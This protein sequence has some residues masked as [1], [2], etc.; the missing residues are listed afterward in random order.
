MTDWDARAE[1]PDYVIHALQDWLTTPGVQNHDM[2]SKV[3]HWVQGDAVVL[4]S[5]QRVALRFAIRQLSDQAR[6]TEQRA[7]KPRDDSPTVDPDRF[8]RMVEWSHK[9]SEHVET[10]KSIL[11]ENT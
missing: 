2:Y 3:A 1:T 8:T 7:G 9:V 5:A 6:Y 4:T 11:K 10:L